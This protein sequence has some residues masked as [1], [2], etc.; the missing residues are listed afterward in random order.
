MNIGKH[1]LL[2]TSFLGLFSGVKAQSD[3]VLAEQYRFLLMDSNQI[4]N[5]HAL[6]SF[7]AKLD[8][9]ERGERKQVRVVHIGDSHIQADFFSGQMRLLMQG[10]FGN[11]GRGFIFPYRAAGTNGPSDY[12][13]GSYGEWDNKRVVFTNKP[14]PIGL[15]GIT[16]A[17]SDTNSLVYIRLREEERAMY[18]FDK[19]TVF[20]QPGPGY[21]DLAMGTQLPEG[22]KTSSTPN[23]FNWHVVRSGE[24]LGLIARKYGTSVAQIKRLNGMRSDFIR[25]GQKLK[26][27][28]V[29]QK[30]VESADTAFQD[31]YCLPALDGQVAAT[32]LLNDTTGTLYL[33]H[34]NANATQQSGLI[35]GM[36]VERSNSSGLLYHTIG[37]NGAQATHYN[38]A[39]FFTDQV[40][41]LQP[42]LI[43]LSLGTNESF[44]TELD[45]YEFYAALDTMVSR[46]SR[47]NPNAVFLICSQP[48]TYKRR[49]Y[50][51]ERNLMIRETLETYSN[52][53]YTGFWDLNSVMGGY[54]SMNDWYRAGLT[55]RDK[56]H[57]SAGGYRLQGQLLFNALMR[58][59]QARTDAELGKD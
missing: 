54:G 58:A 7:F 39:A 9:L 20:R 45:E 57:F 49:R 22:I 53:R 11:A 51:N 43:I 44:A 30:Q 41:H 23:G 6:E 27:G 29:Y 31:L 47:T 42:D 37:V 34:T 50:K 4:K 35:Y 26:V 14:L 1:I 17:S 52:D 5:V 3:S 38:E 16:L 55:A 2:L 21:F 33:R 18:A 36:S 46:L 28:V 13:S 15:S 8:E 10:Q 59:Y 12:R 48:D 25:A 24:S 32:C 40:Q 19:V 56:V